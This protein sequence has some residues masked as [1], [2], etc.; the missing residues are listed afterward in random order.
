M[1]AGT[2]PQRSIPP[3]VEVL[4]ALLAEVPAT[5]EEIRA[6]RER[7]LAA[8][9]RFEPSK[10]PVSAAI[11]RC[12]AALRERAAEVRRVAPATHATE[13]RP[14]LAF[15]ERATMAVPPIAEASAGPVPGPVT[16][17][18]MPAGNPPPAVEAAETTPAHWT[19]R[20]RLLYEDVLN[21][22]E[23]GDQAGAMTSLERLILSLIHI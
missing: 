4:A 8:A 20:E 15:H 1:V 9:A 3:T 22:F 5:E 21:L 17:D 6:R 7:A 2:Q 23:L 11:G 14:E 10:D 12:V 19:T 18:T 16:K 13:P